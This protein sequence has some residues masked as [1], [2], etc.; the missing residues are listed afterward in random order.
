MLSIE[1]QGVEVFN[2]NVKF[3][4]LSFQ[5]NLELTDINRIASKCICPLWIL[6]YLGHT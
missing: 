6:K 3:V 4:G 1:V 2:S 5:F